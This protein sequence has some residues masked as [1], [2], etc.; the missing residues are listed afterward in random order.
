MTPTPGKDVQVRITAK[1]SVRAV[2]C[3]AEVWC[4]QMLLAHIQ[5]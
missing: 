2:V 1:A 5:G 4:A 3:S